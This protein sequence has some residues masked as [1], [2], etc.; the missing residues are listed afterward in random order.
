MTWRV[1]PLV[2][3]KPGIATCL[4]HGRLVRR[5]VP[6]RVHRC[7]LPVCQECGVLIVRAMTPDERRGR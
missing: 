5:I 4:D 2:D 6:F 3:C 7:R 1:S